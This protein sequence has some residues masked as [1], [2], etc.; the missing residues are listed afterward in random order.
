MKAQRVIIYILNCLIIGSVVLLSCA[1]V[2]TEAPPPEPVEQIKTVSKYIKQNESAVLNLNDG[3]S[4][5]IPSDSLHQDSEILVTKEG[6]NIPDSDNNE[7]L[8]PGDIY[9]I[10]IKNDEFFKN[11]VKITIPFE[12]DLLPQNNKD[13][14][15][16]AIFWNDGQ[17]NEVYGDMDNKNYTITVNTIH[18]SIWTW[19]TYQKNKIGQEIALNLLD[20]DETPLTLEEAIEIM[21]RRKRESDAIWERLEDEVDHL[22]YLSDPVVIANKVTFGVAEKISAVGMHKLAPILGKAGATK[23]AVTLTSSMGHVI[24]TIS[25]VT[26]TIYLIEWTYSFSKYNDYWYQYDR[27]DYRLR[28]AECIMQLLAETGNVHY[29]DPVCFV[30][31][32]EYEKRLRELEIEIPDFI[33]LPLE[34]A[35]LE[36]EENGLEIEIES[37]ITCPESFNRET[38]G[39][40]YPPSGETLKPG[41]T[42]TLFPCEEPSITIPDVVGFSKGAAVDKIEDLGFHV[43]IEPQVTCDPEYKENDIGIQDPPAGEKLSYGGS[44]TLYPCLTSTVSVPDVIGDSL[45]SAE[46]QIE[47][48]GLQVS[49]GSSVSCGSGDDENIV[50]DQNPYSGTTLNIGDTV[51]LY[52]CEEPTVIVPDV[53][54]YSRSSAENK[55]ENLG[56]RVSIGSSV[57]CS[58]G[59]DEDTVGDQSP[60]GGST[61]KLGDTITLYPCKEPTVT[62][63]NVEGYS[64]SSAENKIENLGLR[65]SI[66]SSVTCSSGDD[67]DTVGDQSPSGG[68]TA[69]LGDTVNLYPCEEPPP[70]PLGFNCKVDIPGIWALADGAQDEFMKFDQNNS[71]EWGYLGYSGGEY[72]FDKQ[73]SGLYKCLSGNGLLINLDKAYEEEVEISEDKNFMWLYNINTGAKHK[74][75]KIGGY[76]TPP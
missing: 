53:E 75:M 12:P 5:E 52:P 73:L 11:P 32:Q 20:L 8:F 67:E 70:P 56:L 39:D 66:G 14:Q 54:G 18:N 15:L 61:A 51:K 36:L 41:D 74:W 28:E 47:G 16:F 29:V 19:A 9:Q 57:T 21:N 43:V 3:F 7:Y 26:G 31:R 63:P 72:T 68:S 46:D 50:G 23:V 64:L 40:Q 38:V 4:L 2:P 42:V 65:V 49:F 25:A 55:I 27:A 60:S 44:V 58:S 22:V 13:I 37:P 6:I 17:W 30:F 1:P 10:E 33:G 76:L 62:V 71:V 34:Y 45:S 35:E 24:G 59:D 69:K 48:L